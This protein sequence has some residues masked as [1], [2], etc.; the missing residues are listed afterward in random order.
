MDAAACDRIVRAATLLGSVRAE[1]LQHWHWFGYHVVSVTP[2]IRAIVVACLDLE[3]ISAD[4]PAR[5]L[6]ELAAIGGRE[7]YDPHYDQLL[8]KLAEILVMRQVLLMPWPE[9]TRFLIEGRAVGSE[10]RVDLVVTQPDGRKLGFEVKAPEYTRHTEC[11]ERGRF[12]LP[13]RGP[14]GTLDQLRELGDPIVLPRDNAV[15]DFLRSANEKFAA[16]KAAGNFTGVLVVVWDDYVYEAIAPLVYERQGLLTPQSYSQIAGAAEA[17]TNVD[18]VM[19][20]RHLSYFVRAAAEQ[21]LGDER[22]HAFHIGGAGALP[23]V[24]ARV[25]GGEELPSA[26]VDGFNALAIDDPILETMAE[27]LPSEIIFWLDY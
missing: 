25:P 14:E 21:P 2:F 10:R 4:A 5:M 1:F 13:A 19:V 22:L 26:A 12:Q 6:R 20:L 16:F 17:F 15:R 11:R 27:Y 24:V 3:R 7:R 9:G 18:A 8:Q 23:N